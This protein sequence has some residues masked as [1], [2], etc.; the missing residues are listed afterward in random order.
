MKIFKVIFTKHNSID[1][2]YSY[3]ESLEGAVLDAHTR[4]HSI[5]ILSVRECKMSSF[6]FREWD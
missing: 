1:F 5:S 6:A 2:L 3:A 4:C